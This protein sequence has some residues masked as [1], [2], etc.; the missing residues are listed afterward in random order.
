MAE[1]NEAGPMA[2][3]ATEGGGN[4]PASDDEV[5]CMWVVC[6]DYGYDGLGEPFT[7]LW[8]KA[9]ADEFVRRAAIHDVGGSVRRKI[10]RAELIEDDA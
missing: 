6:V 7:V 9:D 5:G 10:I 2:R 8:T 3:D 4:V 1:I